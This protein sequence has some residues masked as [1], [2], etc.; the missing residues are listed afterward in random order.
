MLSG[1][2]RWGE[3]LKQREEQVQRPL[4]GESMLP[5]KSTK[6]V[7]KEGEQG[8]IGWGLKA[9]GLVGGGQG[10]GFYSRYCCKLLEGY[11]RKPSH[12]LFSEELTQAAGRQCWVN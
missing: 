11:T 10:S 12:V 5:K 1:Q 8:G 3:S 9:E 6:D 4:G 7:K 2:N